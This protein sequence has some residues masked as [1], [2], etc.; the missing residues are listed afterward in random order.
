VSVNLENMHLG[1]LAS[2]DQER[3]TLPLRT[4]SLE[5]RGTGGSVHE[6]LAAANGKLSFRQGTEQIID[7][8]SSRFFG[9]LVLQIIRTLDPSRSAKE[10]MTL[11]CAIFD[12]DIKEGIATIENFALKTD[13]LAI[14]ARGNVD[15]GNERL[16]LSV[17]ATPRKGFGISIGDVATSFVKIGGTLQRPQ[18]KIDPTGSVTT[19]GAALAT[20]GLSLVA[21][22][23]WNKLAAKSD[24]C[25]DRKRQQ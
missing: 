15:F 25:K 4:G 10:Q 7:L 20:G 5:L 22:G 8:D 12:V 18:M 6:L 3:A 19:G 1:M 13:K 17:R 11:Q 23:V 2:K 24:F 14:V 21:K 16:K 9:D